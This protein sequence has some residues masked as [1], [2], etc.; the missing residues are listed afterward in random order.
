M[1]IEE[2]WNYF[3]GSLTNFAKILV[4]LSVNISLN[5]GIAPSKI[6][7]KSQGIN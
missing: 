1:Q 5:W 2:N 7:N 3:T 6:F 4:Y